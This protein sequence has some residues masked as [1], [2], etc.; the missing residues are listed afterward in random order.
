MTCH[1]TLLGR[2]SAKSQEIVRNAHAIIV[3]QS[4]LEATRQGQDRLVKRHGSRAVA[5]SHNGDIRFSAPTGRTCGC[6]L[7]P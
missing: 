4:A 1:H 3:W 6:D 5:K 7:P 2:S